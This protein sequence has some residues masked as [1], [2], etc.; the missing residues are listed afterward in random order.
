MSESC[1]AVILAAG[2]SKRLG[3]PKQLLQ[4]DGE[5]LIRRTVRFATEAGCAPV[6][7]VVGAHAE[8]ITAEL[9]SSGAM[10]F[11][12]TKW[13]EGI[14]TSIRCGVSSLLQIGPNISNIVFLVCDQI[15]LSV[16][17]L[18]ELQSTSDAHRLDIVAS[19][20]AGILG[21]PAIFPREFFQ[22][23][24]HLRGDRGARQVI[25]KYA[26]RVKAVAFDGGNVDVDTTADLALWAG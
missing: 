25:K 21:V 11:L 9:C 2:A 7:V 5:S 15:R 13:D 18:R 20:Y 16:T 1:G 23:L 26:H 6:C 4:I 8:Q 24:Q 3:H 17:V 12:N 14:G 10:T 22:E 19:E